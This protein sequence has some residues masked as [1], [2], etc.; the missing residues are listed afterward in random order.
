[1][2]VTK[3]GIMDIDFSP[4][5]T[6]IATF[7]KYGKYIYIYIKYLFSNFVLTDVLLIK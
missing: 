7:E 5:N 1:M 2:E 4:R 6:Y 3:R